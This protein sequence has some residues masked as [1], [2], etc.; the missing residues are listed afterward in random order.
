LPQAIGNK[1]ASGAA[2]ILVLI[3][4]GDGVAQKTARELRAQGNTRVVILAGG[5]MTIA[6]QG[7]RGSQRTGLS[8]EN[9]NKAITGAAK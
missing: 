7:E 5:E 8:L 3:D 1:A 4:N 9:F 6:R 2:P